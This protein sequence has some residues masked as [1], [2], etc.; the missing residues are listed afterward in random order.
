[1]GCDAIRYDVMPDGKWGHSSSSRSNTLDLRSARPRHGPLSLLLPVS[2]LLSHR[3][4]IVFVQSDCTTTGGVAPS[5]DP[6]QMSTRPGH[7]H[8]GRAVPCHA[9]SWVDAR[10][11]GVHCRLSFAHP[12]KCHPGKMPC[13]SKR[14][15]AR[16]GIVYRADGSRLLPGPPMHHPLRIPGATSR[17]RCPPVRCEWQVFVSSPLLPTA[18]RETE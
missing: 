3:V 4:S 5:S 13:N 2:P 18:L 7:Y 10:D 9:M 6:Q 1:M 16:R 8:I 12:G 17:V 14:Q 11:V 15:T